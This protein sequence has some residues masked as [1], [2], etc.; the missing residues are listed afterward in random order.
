MVVFFSMYAQKP[1]IMFSAAR[2]GTKIAQ[3]LLEA[4]LI[5]LIVRR[6]PQLQKA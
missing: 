4:G 1:E 6:Q 5:A 3:I 2:L